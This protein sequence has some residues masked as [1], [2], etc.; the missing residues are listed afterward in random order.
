MIGIDTN[1]L[2]YAHRQD[3]PL[4][5]PALELLRTLPS[6]GGL[7]GVPWPCVHEFLAVVTNARIFRDPTPAVAALQAVRA[8]AEHPSIRML[9]EGE[10]YIDH[11]AA[12]VTRGEVRGGMIHDARIAAICRYHG[13]R[14]LWSADRDFSRF[15]DLR[16]INPLI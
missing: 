5:A 12:Q 7:F 9:G 16:A 15:P 8:L 11:L 10:G 2:V 4:H 14:E 1:L 13:I 6:R 3:M